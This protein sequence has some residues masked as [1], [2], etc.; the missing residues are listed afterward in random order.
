MDI[1]DCRDEI[2]TEQLLPVIDG[3]IANGQSSLV[4]LKCGLCN[5]IS[6]ISREIDYSG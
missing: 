6:A 3:N 1:F 2:L 4:G 5:N